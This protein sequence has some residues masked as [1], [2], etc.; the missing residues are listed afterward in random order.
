MAGE[1]PNFLQ[2]PEMGGVIDPQVS[3]LE[4][5]YRAID[6]K[7]LA[8]VYSL[9]SPKIV[10]QRGKGEP[11]KGIRQFRR[12]YEAPEGRI[13]A[14]GNHTNLEFAS[15]PSHVEVH[16]HFSGVLKNGDAVEVDFIDRFKFNKKGKIT[17]RVTTFPEGQREI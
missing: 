11:M 2:A 7:D 15:T 10:Y 17:T 4:K 8:T 14:S 5:Y 12:F 13:I 1:R 6:D 9:F 16:G 3:S